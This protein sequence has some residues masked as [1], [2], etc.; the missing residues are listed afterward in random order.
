MEIEENDDAEQDGDAEEKADEKADLSD[1]SDVEDEDGMKKDEEPS[2]P[3]QD[4]GKENEDENSGNQDPDTEEPGKPE[5]VEEDEEPSNN[6]DSEGKNEANKNENFHESIDRPSTEE[7]VQSMP[8][9]KDQGSTDQVETETDEKNVQEDKL[10]AQDTGKYGQKISKLFSSHFVESIP[11]PLFISQVKNS[12]ALGRHQTKSRSPAI[13]VLLML[14]T[15]KRMSSLKRQS[16]KIVE[17]RVQQMKIE[18]LVTIRRAQNASLKLYNKWINKNK[19][20]TTL[21][22]KQTSTIQTMN[23]NT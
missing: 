18:R 16:K 14:K 10:D 5:A 2:K 22:H 6:E 21:H 3:D 12:L 9:S 7:N 8:E 19:W 1:N 4:Q 17:N 11:M 13:K 20:T 23:S 15:P